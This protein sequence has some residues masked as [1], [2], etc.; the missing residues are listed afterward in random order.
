MDRV[1]YH[2]KCGRLFFDPRKFN[3]QLKGPYRANQCQPFE[4]LRLESEPRYVCIIPL[5]HLKNRI[6]CER[7]C[8]NESISYTNP[9][10]S[11][12]YSHRLEYS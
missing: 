8:L 1:K 11:E 5:D 2:K 4:A 3:D 10:Y 12:A 9:L 7:E 6:T